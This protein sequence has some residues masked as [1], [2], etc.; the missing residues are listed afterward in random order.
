LQ[1]QH[2]IRK[3][4]GYFNIKPWDQ[5]QDIRNEIMRI[6]NELGMEVLS[7]LGVLATE[8]APGGALPP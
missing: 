1:G 4:E 3:K 2:K 7:Q 8:L 5:H 6:A